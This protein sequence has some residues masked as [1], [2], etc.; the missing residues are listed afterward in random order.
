MAEHSPLSPS[1]LILAL[2]SRVQILVLTPASRLGQAGSSIRLVTLALK[3]ETRTE[4]SHWEAFSGRLFRSHESELNNH[5]LIFNS[6]TFAEAFMDCL[7]YVGLCSSCRGKKF[8]RCSHE[9]VGVPNDVQRGTPSYQG[10]G[11][12]CDSKQLWVSH[13]LTTVTLSLS[14]LKLWLKDCLENVNG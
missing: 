3:G 10:Y 7:L 9:H 1:L 13:S 8:L 11:L 5:R 2:K 12:G 14:I 4:D 6:L